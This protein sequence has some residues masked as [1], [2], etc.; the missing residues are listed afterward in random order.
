M[1]GRLKKFSRCIDGSA[2][3]EHSALVAVLLVIGYFLYHEVP[4][5]PRRITADSGERIDAS[6]KRTAW[7]GTTTG[8]NPD[9]SVIRRADRIDLKYKNLEKSISPAAGPK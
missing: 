7:P 9:T 8:I 6:W 1:L 2:M 3:M 5:S 4:P